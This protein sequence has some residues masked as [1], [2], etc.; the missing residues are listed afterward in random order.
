MP[1]YY[2]ELLK[3]ELNTLNGK[4]ILIMGLSY[5]SNVKEVAFSGAITLINILNEEKAKVLIED[6]LYSESELMNF[7]SVSHNSFDSEVDG[8]IIHTAHNEF[9][10]LNSRKFR[11]DCVIVDGRGIFSKLLPKPIFE[12]K[13]FKKRYSNQNHPREIK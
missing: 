12:F 1:K 13:K 6:P 3:R 2:V 8:I 11:D 9:L 7:A 10:N 5:R 4:N